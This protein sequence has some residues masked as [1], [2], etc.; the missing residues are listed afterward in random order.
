MP[1][2]IE[3]IDHIAVKKRRDVTYLQIFSCVDGV[4]PVNDEATTL[5]VTSWLDKNNISWEVCALPS[6]NEIIGGP[7]LIYLDV[8]FEQNNQQYKLLKD[9]LENDDGSMKIE[10]CDWCYMPLDNA[11]KKI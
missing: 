9:Y 2:L 1:Q 5:E 6:Y 3:H 7:T 8:P 10:N 4:F 11:M